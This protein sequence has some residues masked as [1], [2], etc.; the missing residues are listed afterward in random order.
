[1]DSSQESSERGE[2]L[3]GGGRD[4]KVKSKEKARDSKNDRKEV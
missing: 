1:M 4:P 2:P 3:Y